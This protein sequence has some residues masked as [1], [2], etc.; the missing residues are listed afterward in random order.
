MDFIIPVFNLHSSSAKEIAHAIN[1]MNF[2]QRSFCI[3]YYYN[4]MFNTAFQSACCYCLCYSYSIIFIDCV[5][6]IPEQLE[7]PW[8]DFTANQVQTR[9]MWSLSYRRRWEC[10]KMHGFTYPKFPKQ[11]CNKAFEIVWCPLLFFF[12]RMHPLT[13]AA[14][15]SKF[16]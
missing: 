3:T 16:K 7:L 13:L 10:L 1:V 14:I 12:H 11:I 15:R 4:N 8:R 9:V 2:C 5:I 6:I